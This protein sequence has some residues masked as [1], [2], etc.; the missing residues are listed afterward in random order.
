M[1][2]QKIDSSKLR[3]GDLLFCIESGGE[4]SRAI[5]QATRTQ[6]GTHYSHVAMIE[7]DADSLWVIHAAPGKGVCREAIQKFFSSEQPFQV[8][9][10]RLDKRWRHT[11]NSAIKQ[12]CSLIGQPYNTSYRINDEGVYCSELIWLV[13][14]EASIFDLSPMRFH[15]PI[16]GKLIEGWE[17]HYKKLGI[18]VP[19][20]E[21]GCNPNGMAASAKIKRVGMLIYP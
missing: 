6:L 13:F 11:I 3:T 12:A 14:R 8:D 20:G 5:D 4:L 7:R 21:L 17:E 15:D 9:V 10:F 16:T 19:E 1:P 2:A 18:K